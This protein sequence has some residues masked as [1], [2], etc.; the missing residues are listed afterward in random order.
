MNLLQKV[1]LY[2]EQHCLIPNKD[3]LLIAGISGGAD[4]IALVSILQQLGYRLLLAHCN[5]QLRGVESQRDE[6]FVTNFATTHNLPITIT[7]FE[8][9]KY[10]RD[11]KLSI[12]MAA[13][14]LRYQWFDELL[15]INQAYAVVV[16]HH[17]DD[18]AET[19]LLNLI[20][21]T[22]LRGLTGIQPVNQT[23]IRPL[24]CIN[25]SEI[26]LYLQDNTLNYVEDSS[27]D[28]DLFVRNKIRHQLIPMLETLNP[29]FRTTMQTN[30][31][32]LQQAWDFQQYHISI[33]RTEIVQTEGNTHVIALEKLRSKQ[34]YR[35]LLF[36]L[37]QEYSFNS[38]QVNDIIKT[39]DG[40]SG[41]LFYSPTHV[42]LKDRNKLIINRIY[43][44]EKT[45]EP[46]FSVRL[47]PRTE[48]STISVAPDLI[49]VDAEKIQFPL[50]LRPMQT[51]DAF[52]PLGMKGKK[53][54][55]DFLIDLKVDR[56]S[57]ASIR[58]ITDNTGNIVWVAGLRIDNR[59][60]I[61]TT[62][63]MIAEIYVF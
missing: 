24:L 49:H 41:K 40:I 37:L 29:S 15:H 9:K 47:F 61:T 45:H 25:R 63:T 16:G 30:I 60:R 57:K 21:G 35:L 1:S 23:I 62:T 3:Q 36:E 19:V 33:L 56:I 44:S 13:R 11:N 59:F 20:R 53:K 28:S 42:L 14:A 46:E 26:L 2:I 31:Q 17:A 43:E 27:N 55:S 22:G 7:H 34:Q 58:L 4:S 51:G 32:N 50:H 5:F 10:A 6:Q 54:L 8:T 38:T 18:S 39:L 12:E 48:I 52:Y